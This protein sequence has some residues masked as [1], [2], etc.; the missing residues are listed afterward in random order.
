MS[1]VS[2]FDLIK[3]TVRLK[4]IASMYFALSGLLNVH[5]LTSFVLDQ[6]Y[7]LTIFTYGSATSL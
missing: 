6:T 2:Y 5:I 7:F 1:L 3:V 4:M